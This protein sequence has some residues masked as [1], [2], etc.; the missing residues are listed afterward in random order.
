MPFAPSGVILVHETPADGSRPSPATGLT[1]GTR[2]AASGATSGVALLTAA[3]CALLATAAGAAAQ[4]R[5]ARWTLGIETGA[6]FAATLY[7]ERVTVWLPT[8]D[9]RSDTRHT[10]RLELVPLVRLVARLR[11]EHGLGGYFALQ[12]TRANTDMSFLGGQATVPD[13]RIAR[14][15]GIMAAELGISMRLG[16][17]ADGRGLAEYTM[18]PVFVRHRLDLRRGHRDGIVRLLRPELQPIPWRELSWTSWGFA[19]GGGIRVPVGDRFT[20][21]LAVH[22]QIVPMGTGQMESQEREEFRRLTDKSPVVTYKA[23]TAH[24]PSVRVGVE[25]LLS[26]EPRRV[27]LP[28]LALTGPEPDTPASRQTLA[29][30][31]LLAAGDTAAA[32]AALEAQLRDQPEDGSAMR[33]YAL[34]RA[35]QIGERPAGRDEV[36]E[37]LRRALL[38]NPVDEALLAEYGRLSALAQRA[39]PTAAAP[40]PLAISELNVRADAAGGLSLGW[41]IHRLADAGEGRGLFSVEVEVF[42][43]GGGAVPIRT[44]G[45]AGAAEPRL[46]L[47]A[48]AAPVGE[49]WLERLEL[50]LAELRTGPHS[51]RVRVQDRTSGQRAERTAGFELR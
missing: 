44:A 11:P 27:P 7:D 38:L 21:R 43:P 9:V 4:E 48:R 3:V 30:R 34:L 19:L 14:S 29:A 36:W 28:V 17:W 2:P 49:P 50:R 18:A 46:V 15:V 16:E 12:A 23:F 31:R 32:L 8:E 26:R 10:E 41:A 39:G 42:G 20:G 45:E 40:E 1:A 13:T 47:E 24:Y 33:E 51:V 25:Y 6:Q 37:L 35:R 5:P 22:N